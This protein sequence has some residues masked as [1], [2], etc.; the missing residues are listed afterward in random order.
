MNTVKRN[1]IILMVVCVAG[2]P[3]GLGTLTHTLNIFVLVGICIMVAG[4]AIFLRV[5][6]TKIPEEK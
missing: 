4:S 2:I 6:K 3:I 1:M 5:P